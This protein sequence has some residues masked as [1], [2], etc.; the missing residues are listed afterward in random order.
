MA[1]PEP[2]AELTAA[3]N[4]EP[5]GGEVDG[6]KLTMDELAAL[7]RGAVVDFADAND[8]KRISWQAL[9]LEL[10]VAKAKAGEVLKLIDKQDA[11]AAGSGGR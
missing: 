11:A 7:A 1:S 9:G 10:G 6:R 4:R 2:A 5:A 8:G 3:Q